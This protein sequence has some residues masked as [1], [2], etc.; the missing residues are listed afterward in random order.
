MSKDIIE[1]GDRGSLRRAGWWEQ[2]HHVRVGH[3][4]ASARGCDWSSSKRLLQ[5][6]L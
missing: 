6:Y 3:A 4:T 1:A 2:G 5:A